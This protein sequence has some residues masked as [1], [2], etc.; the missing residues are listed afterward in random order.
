MPLSE[1]HM[2]L[3]R[4]PRRRGLWWWRRRQ[5]EVLA[6]LRAKVVQR[7]REQPDRSANRRHERHIERPDS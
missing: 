6:T 3:T 4:F 7:V 1:E 5:D 2:H